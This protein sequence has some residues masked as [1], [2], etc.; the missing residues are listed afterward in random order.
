MDCLASTLASKGKAA[1]WGLL[2]VNAVFGLS[3]C[4]LLFVVFGRVV[5]GEVS[6]LGGGVVLLLLFAQASGHFLLRVWAAKLT[7][8]IMF[9]VGV[10]AWLGWAAKMYGVG[11]SSPSDVD[12]FPHL[13]AVVVV[14]FVSVVNYY[15]LAND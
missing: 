3:Y 5:G 11:S 7:A 6:L 14:F 8:V 10:I 4:Y 1:F 2:L 12:F 13:V 15:L 9:F